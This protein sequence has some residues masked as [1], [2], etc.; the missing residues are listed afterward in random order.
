MHFF[1]SSKLHEDKM[2]TQYVNYF[3][4]RFCFPEN[5]K[6]FSREEFVSYCLDNSLIPFIRIYNSTDFEIREVKGIKKNIE[7]KVQE[8]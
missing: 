3:R 1:D 8:Q 4:G 5:G 2:G 6:D 7:R